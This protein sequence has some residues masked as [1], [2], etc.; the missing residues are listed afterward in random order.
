MAAP[1]EILI[2]NS[3]TKR[4]G[5]ALALF[6]RKAHRRNAPETFHRSDAGIDSKI[7]VYCLAGMDD[8]PCFGVDEGCSIGN[9]S[10]RTEILGR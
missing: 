2:G 6:I 7:N 8:L 1:R 3:E 9:G 10:G 5:R 4:I